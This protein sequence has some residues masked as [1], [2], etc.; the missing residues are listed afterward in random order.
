MGLAQKLCPKFISPYRILEELDGDLFQVNLSPALKRRGIHETFH[1]SLL[2]IHIPNDDC[3][4]PERTDN[5]MFEADEGEREWAVNR[6][7]S[8]AE[9]R[10]HATFEILWCS[11]DKSWLPFSQI[12]HLRALEEYLEAMGI[13]NILD[14]PDGLGRPPLN[15]PQVF[16]RNIEITGPHY[17]C[18]LM[19]DM[20]PPPPTSM[21]PPLPDTALGT[22]NPSHLQV[23]L[24]YSA[25]YAIV[26]PGVP[27][28]SNRYLFQHI[29]TSDFFVTMPH[30]QFTVSIPAFMMRRYLQFDQL[31]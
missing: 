14:L 15:D 27:V 16:A 30:A 9:S 18:M 28:G 11:E 10:K 5:Q 1:A 6:I 26:N 12:S 24:A 7:V 4:F 29:E 3:L 31:A 22:V 23:I 25:G 17:R 19:S 8:H 13:D 2:R 21:P 20:Q